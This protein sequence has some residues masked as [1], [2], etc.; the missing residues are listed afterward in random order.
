M[1]VS[2]PDVFFERESY[3]LEERDWEVTQVVVVVARSGDLSL[4]SHVRV[5]SQDSG[6][7]KKAIDYVAVD[8]SQ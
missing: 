1:C 2:V 4:G 7:A 6:S 5:I 8:T 3:G